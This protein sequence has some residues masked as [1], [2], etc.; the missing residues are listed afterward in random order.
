MGFLGSVGSLFSGGSSKSTPYQMSNWNPEQ[1]KIFASL[2]Q[3]VN[4]QGATPT[5]PFQTYA[6]ANPTEQA[7]MDYAKGGTARAGTAD[8]AIAKLFAGPAF[9]VDPAT[10]EQVVQNAIVPGYDRAMDMALSKVGQ[11]FAGTG[12]N[13]SGR[14]IATG[15]TATDMGT[16]MASD[17]AQLRYG[18][19]QATRQGQ[20]DWYNRMAQVAP[21]YGQTQTA[22][23][24]AGGQ[25][26]RSIEEQKIM[27]DLARWT[28]GEE[29][30]GT[31][32]PFATASTK[33]GLSL[34]G[35]SPYSVGSQTESSGPGIL[36]AMLTGF[37]GGAGKVAGGALFA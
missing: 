15:T 10:T 24:A 31:Y 2:S 23:A 25:L 7:F 27:S 30:G 22:T 37:A 11:Q 35:F 8:T 1:Q 16:K 29:M 36:N 21:G 14:A 26:G 12:Y 5:T 20:T 3:M 34:L 9:A 4:N 32:N 17:I 28:S 18:D 33:L 19:T 6:S 13:S